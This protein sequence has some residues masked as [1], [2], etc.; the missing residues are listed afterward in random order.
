MIIYSPFLQVPHLEDILLLIDDVDDD[1]LEVLLSRLLNYT[2]AQTSQS[3]TDHTLLRDPKDY[4]ILY[5]DEIVSI[6]SKLLT[7]GSTL[8][9]GSTEVKADVICHLPPKSSCEHRNI[10][11]GP[12]GSARSQRSRSDNE[13]QDNIELVDV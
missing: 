1:M 2:K 9:Y 3:E 11:D 5:S 8:S 4:H 13:V 7:E 10:L 12:R 6:Q